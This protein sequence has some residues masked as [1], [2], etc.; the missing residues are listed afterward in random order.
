M[1]EVEK[2][3]FCY[4]ILQ[5]HDARKSSEKNISCVE[6]TTNKYHTNIE[7]YTRNLIPLMWQ[8]NNKNPDNARKE[9]RKKETKCQPKLR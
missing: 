1:T 3:N 4:E 7:T 2:R 8:N 6:T 5:S 9:Q